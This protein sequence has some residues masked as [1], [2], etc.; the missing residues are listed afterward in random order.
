[1][2]AH[3]KHFET[4]GE[5]VALGPCPGTHSLP[6]LHALGPCPGLMHPLT[7]TVDSLWG[8]MSYTAGEIDVKGYFF[9]AESESGAYWLGET[10]WKHYSFDL[11]L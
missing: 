5:R 9:M 11:Y 2:C 10:F 8:Q 7:Q 4:D 3:T 1:M 6:H